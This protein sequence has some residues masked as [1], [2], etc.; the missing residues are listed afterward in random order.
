MYK[1]IKKGFFSFIPKEKADVPHLVDFFFRS[2]HRFAQASQI[3]MIVHRSLVRT[4][5]LA[6]V[7]AVATPRYA[8]PDKPLRFLQCFAAE[9]ALTSCCALHHGSIA[10]TVHVIA[11][12]IKNKIHMGS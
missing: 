6:A 7:C 8:W 1:I 9:G 3:A 4:F 5:A 12:V 11:R 2:A 10:S